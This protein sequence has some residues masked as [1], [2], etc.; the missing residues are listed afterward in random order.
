MA[1]A[2]RLLAQLIVVEIETPVQIGE[3]TI[4]VQA[5]AAILVTAKATPTRDVDPKVDVV[6][7]TLHALR[8]MPR[9]GTRWVIVPG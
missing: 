2:T 6:E 7:V 5:R 8:T 3:V 1:D 4:A 9:D